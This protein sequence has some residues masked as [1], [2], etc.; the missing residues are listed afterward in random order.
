MVAPRVVKTALLGPRV[1][2]LARKAAKQPRGDIRGFGTIFSVVHEQSHILRVIGTDHGACWNVLWAY[3]PCKSPFPRYR[4]NQPSREGGADNV[5][6]ANMVHR[7][8]PRLTITTG[9]SVCRANISTPRRNAWASEQLTTCLQQNLNKRGKLGI[10]LGRLRAK[11]RRR[12]SATATASRELPRPN[13]S[14]IR[15]WNHFGIFQIRFVKARNRISERE[16]TFYP[17][18]PRASS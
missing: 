14:P 3:P 18:T 13:T 17:L 9:V 4:V 12:E 11:P 16:K 7:H 6:V 8:G 1:P 15:R 5:R 2:P 10:A